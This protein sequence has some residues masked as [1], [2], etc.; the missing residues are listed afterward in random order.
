MSNDELNRLLKSA[1]VP[2]RE[3]EYWADFPPSVTG[4]LRAGQSSAFRRFEPRRTPLLFWGV[5]FATAC[6]LIAFAIGS[7][8]GCESGLSASQ[9]A[10]MQK[11]FHE[12]EALFPN[13]VR[14]IVIDENGPR[15]VLSE[16]ADVPTS[17]PLLLRISGRHGT[18]SVVTFSGQQILVNGDLCDVLADAGGHILVVGNK[19]VWSNER[20]GLRRAPYRIAAQALENSL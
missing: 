12:V 15:L 9:V 6:V 2:E 19:F 8:R 3:A 1:P 18:Q 11:Y 16:R 5:G 14:A 17:P 7:W 20:Q 4:R 13:Q 10:A